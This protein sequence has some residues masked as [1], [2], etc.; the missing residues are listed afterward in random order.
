[1]DHSS[2]ERKQGKSGR[3]IKGD[4]TAMTPDKARQTISGERR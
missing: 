3:T 4:G 2:P 1:M